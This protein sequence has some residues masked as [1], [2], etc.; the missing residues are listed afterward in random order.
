MLS[1]ILRTHVQKD[2]NADE[3]GEAERRGLRPADRRTGAGIYFLEGH[4]Q[5]IH[6]ANRI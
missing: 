5:L 2:V 4:L 1:W 3:I 6:Q